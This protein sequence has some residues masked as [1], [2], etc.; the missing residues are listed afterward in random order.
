MDRSTRT[1]SYSSTSL[2][3]PRSGGLRCHG[4]AISTRPPCR[5][6]SASSP[7]TTSCLA[8]VLTAKIVCCHTLRL[9]W[10]NIQLL[11][12]LHMI[13]SLCVVFKPSTDGLM[14]LHYYFKVLIGL[15]M[16][17][18]MTAMLILFD[19]AV[20]LYN[21]LIMIGI[22]WHKRKLLLF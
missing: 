20:M 1:P 8:S 11:A 9:C 10:I 7:S 3:C 19:V 12:S 4:T 17:K 13:I 15:I 18:P 2:P 14:T 21:H 16:K 5:P 6:M 22:L